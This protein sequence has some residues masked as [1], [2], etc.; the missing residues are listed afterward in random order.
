[1]KKE[2][3]GFWK[4]VMA[5]MLSFMLLMPTAALAAETENSGNAVETEVVQIDLNAELEKFLQEHDISETE[6]DVSDVDIEGVISNVETEQDEASMSA[7]SPMAVSM[8]VTGLYIFK[9]EGNVDDS[10]QA[11]SIECGQGKHIASNA[12]AETQTAFDKGQVRISVR[13]I[14]THLA[15][16]KQLV[17][18][19]Y[20]SGSG[21]YD[22]TTNGSGAATSFT[23]DY[24]LT[25][26]NSEA[27]Q[28]VFDF[29]YRPYYANGQGYYVDLYHRTLTVNWG[30]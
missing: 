30:E 23:I 7:I 8:P 3:W 28:T 12:S 9:V 10:K 20:V 6:E 14:G 11:E 26:S 19:G 21:A 13:Y 18:D 16:Q 1:M 24:T 29:K 2:N 17:S 5:A 25:P 27:A 4:K 15:W 22:A